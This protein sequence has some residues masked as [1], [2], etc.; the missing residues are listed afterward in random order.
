MR[1]ILRRIGHTHTSPH[2]DFLDP[3]HTRT[4]AKASSAVHNCTNC[5]LIQLYYIHNMEKLTVPSRWYR[6]IPVAFITYSLAYL[7]R[8][9][10]GFGTAG[11][12]TADLGIDQ[13]TSSL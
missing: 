13:R 10:F 4:P 2:L 8:A 11:G 12:M 6:M 7:D 9:N 5:C 3:N 1:K